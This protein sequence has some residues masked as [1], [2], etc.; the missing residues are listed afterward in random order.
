MGDTAER[1]TLLRTETF[2]RDL[3]K[4]L[5][6]HPDRQRLVRETLTAFATDPHAA[7]LRLHPLKGRMGGL[8]SVRLSYS[9]RITLTLLLTERQVV[10]LSMGTH[11]DVY[12]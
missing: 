12:R 5:K 6:K 7:A 8:Y 2:L 11:D 4:Y 3:R 1:W 10:L 9:D